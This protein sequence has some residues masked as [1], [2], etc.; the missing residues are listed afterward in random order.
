MAQ[1]WLRSLFMAVLELTLVAQA[2]LE[3]TKIPL[4]LPPKCALPLPGFPGIS[5][6][7]VV[8]NYFEP[9]T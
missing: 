4:L 9:G 2:G 5:F 8:I 3:F 1:R 7:R 6:V